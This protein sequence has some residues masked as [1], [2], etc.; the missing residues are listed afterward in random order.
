M[1]IKHG[2]RYYRKELY[3]VNKSLVEYSYPF[4]HLTIISVPT[5]DN[6]IDVDSFEKT[7]AERH[8][9]STYK[10]TDT[11]PYWAMLYLIPTYHNPRGSCLPK[12]NIPDL[13]L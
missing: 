12:G 8:K 10:P 6:G 2:D 7:V 3:N 9:T 1:N 11:K 5:D 13:K 4:K